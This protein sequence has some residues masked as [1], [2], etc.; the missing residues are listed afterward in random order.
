MFG[1]WEPVEIMSLHEDILATLRSSWHDIRPIDDTLF[2]SEIAEQWNERMC[3]VLSSEYG[4]APLFIVKEPRLNG[5]LPV[6]LRALTALGIDPYV[7]IAVRNPN[8]VARSLAKRDQFSLT[9]G[10]LLW[11][12]NILD[13]ERHSR[14][15]PRS[16]L[17]FDS[18]FVGRTETLARIGRELG[19]VWPIPIGAAESEIS[20]FLRHEARHHRAGNE[21]LE[22]P[23]IPPGAKD[24]FL[25]LNRATIGDR[26]G[27]E[28]VF[29]DVRL[30]FDPWTRALEP[31]ID[32]VR[33][34]DSGGPA[35]AEFAR[36]L[37]T[38][39]EERSDLRATIENGLRE[40]AIR[41]SD[42]EI[43]AAAEAHLNDRLAYTE[44]TAG[45]LRDLL[46]MRQVETEHLHQRIGVLEYESPQL[47]SR[48][49]KAEA[50]VER[51]SGAL[52]STRA[53]LDR[54]APLEAESPK[55][56]QRL[57]AAELE[58]GR[59]GG[60]LEMA[61]AETIRLAPFQEE[62]PKLWSRVQ[63][64]EAE[65]ARL[66]P[67]EEE[68]P[69][70]WAR[71]NHAEAEVGRLSA[72]VD[73]ARDELAR[74]R[75][76]E[77]QVPG[78]H[79]R[80][81]RFEAESIRLADLEREAPLLWARINDAEAEGQR[82]RAAQTASDA[83]IARLQLVAEEVDRL[84]ARVNDGEAEGER[85]RA[86]RTEGDAEI[87]RL[88]S[89]AE[90]VDRLWARVNEA[91]AEIERL[92][93]IE[94]EVDRLVTRLNSTERD[95]SASHESAVEAELTL[96]RKLA[97]L[98]VALDER[99]QFTIRL[100]A[101][102]GEI[103]DNQELSAS[104]L[105]D[106]KA[107]I[108][109]RDIQIAELTEELADVS[110]QATAQ[111]GA[112]REL[113]DAFRDVRR[114]LGDRIASL[115]KEVESA[116][117]H[118]SGLERELDQ[119][120]RSAEAKDTQIESLTNA[121][122]QISASATS[123]ERKVRDLTHLLE[124]SRRRQTESERRVL[125]YEVGVR[126]LFDEQ[127]IG[128]LTQPWQYNLAK[129]IKPKAEQAAL[130]DC[131]TIAASGMFDAGYYF[132]TN[133]DLL[134]SGIDPLLH[135]VLFGCREGRNPSPDFNTS[136]YLQNNP[137]LIQ[138]KRNPLIHFM[139]H[140]RH[141]GRS[142]R[143]DVGTPAP[144]M[145]P[146]TANQSQRFYSDLGFVM[147]YPER[148]LSHP[149]RQ[150]D[151]ACLDIHWVIPDFLPGAGGHMTIFRI[152][153]LLGQF[154]H[155]QTM[156][157]QNPSAHQSEG[158]A[159][160]TMVRHFQPAA[161]D[162]RFLPDDV[163]EITG[164]AI[165]ATD[166]WTVFP[167]AAMSKF[168][169]RFYFVQDHETQFYPAG[170]HSLLTE[171]TYSLGFDCLCAGE[172]LHRLMGERD[173]WSMKWNLAS[174]RSV[175]HPPMD[176]RPRETNRIA[177][178]SR[179][180]TPRRAVELGMLA[181][182]ELARWGYD[183]HVDF[184]G[185]DMIPLDLP[186]RYTQHGIASSQTLGDLYRR[187]TIGVVFSATNHSLLPREMMACKLPVVELDV[188]SISSVFPEGTLAR[189][190]PHPTA[191]A[192]QIAKLLDDPGLRNAQAEYAFGWQEQFSWEASARMVEAGIIERVGQASRSELGGQRQYT[193]P[194]FA[195]RALALTVES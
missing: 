172:W 18:L 2:H 79:A 93:P 128:K 83:E 181:L 66:R 71:V 118:Q 119:A 155:R 73:G 17:S 163:S 126:R 13:A 76:I 104:Q 193:L 162:I 44:G 166:R 54:L 62:A 7:T 144:A 120:R 99:D 74:L 109:D 14:G 3:G 48:V 192:D 57:T 121:I 141:E 103:L 160:A 85:L 97:E 78:L 72:L 186:Y 110:K 26:S 11:M 164:D 147:K 123:L 33:K 88:R 32:H 113:T 148:P 50:E 158:E 100:R 107:A 102:E 6:I 46:A 42:S 39:V 45:Q 188:D 191:I 145:A 5:L 23:D 21:A 137:D 174:D 29:D 65:V 161:V 139:I 134:G 90:E 183:F 132:A 52:Q 125:D 77:E 184:F 175:Y 86:A 150:P 81:A 69:R 30:R 12:R 27:L 190:A 108:T 63:S 15:L 64:A 136:W 189:A 56:W 49:N 94:A 135:Y 92:R 127:P 58:V 34:P 96:A 25:A 131:A 146:S 43:I 185:A 167:V 37:K 152:A 106:A 154:G 165:I 10:H 20:E 111:E 8:E 67:I 140:G 171:Y 122:D 16:F 180:T 55:L 124:D 194:A 22:G 195:N 168:Y 59:L 91:E 179:L 116:R 38:L 28:A 142:P 173:Q 169:R 187:S 95:L 159:M 19:L 35:A 75:L 80:I 156:W 53:E 178:Y 4:D 84:W 170:S 70:L 157:I 115:T 24:L 60:A 41:R 112:I 117:T 47:W 114:D 182:E 149:A 1:Y 51:L 31:F 153:H 89:V 129:A 101:L 143:P 105:A 138:W 177:F 68:S 133:P 87:A 36:T 151:P 130:R 82:L 176:D 40:I 9:Y 98:Q 61:R